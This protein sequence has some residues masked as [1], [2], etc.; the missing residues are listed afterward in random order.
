[1]V[2]APKNLVEDRL[3]EVGVLNSGR[4]CSSLQE[5]VLRLNGGEE[6]AVTRRPTWA[7]ARKKGLAVR[8]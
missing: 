1:M 6:Q 5:T 3:K 8:G 7:H 2:G 4:G